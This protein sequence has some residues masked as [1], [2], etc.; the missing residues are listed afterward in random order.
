MSSNLFPA[1]DRKAA[2]QAVTEV[3]DNQPSLRYAWGVVGIL[4]FAYTFSFIDRQILSLLVEPIREDLGLTDTG[5]SLLHGLAFAIFYT[6]MG[7]P[8]G[9]LADRSTRKYIIA[10]GITFWSLATAACGL[11]RDFTQLFLARVGV[12]VGEAALSPAAY[13]MISDYFPREKVGR[14]MG[15]YTIGIYVGTGL[16]L[17]VGGAVVEVATNMP[18]IALPWFGEIKAWQLTFFVVGLPGL[19][20]AALVALVKEPA[21]RGIDEKVEEQSF[22]AGLV[23]IWAHRKLYAPFILG[24]SFVAMIGYACN[25]WLPTFFIRAHGFTPGEAGL[26]V[27]LMVL[28]GGAIGVYGGGYVADRMMARGKYSA[29][30]LVIM[31]SG[32]G[33]TIPIA[34]VPFMPTPELAMLAYLPASILTSVTSSTSP[35]AIQLITP[36]EMRGQVSALFLLALNMI[37]LGIGP[38]LVALVTDYSFKDPAMVGYSLAIVCV[39]AVPPA[40][41]L[42]TL[43]LRNFAAR[44][45]EREVRDQNALLI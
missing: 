36:N 17:I 19:L 31:W 38:T 35:A 11:A 3:L 18:P 2:A 40:V 25:L 30:P 41:I 12:G 39:A 21:R 9:R 15:V 14:A 10:I 1:Q 27:G 13:S 22:S 44:I 26:A 28:V 43:S 4:S 7:Y 23:Y 42:L 16:A 34:L 20:I 33:I 8:I 45:K 5:V 6:T 29:Y 24:A 37:G 32:V